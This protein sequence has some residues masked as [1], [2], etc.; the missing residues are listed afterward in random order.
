M[1]QKDLF[2]KVKPLGYYRAVSRKGGVMSAIALAGVFFILHYIFDNYIYGHVLE[3][4]ASME[5]V[6]SLR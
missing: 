4:I 3:T 6:F 5:T 1:A 2:D